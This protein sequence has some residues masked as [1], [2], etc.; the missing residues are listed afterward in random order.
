MKQPSR[1]CY[2]NGKQGPTAGRRKFGKETLPMPSFARGRLAVALVLFFGSVTSWAQTTSASGAGRATQ[3]VI[4]LSQGTAGFQPQNPF[5]GSVPAGTATPNVLPLSLK[6]AIARGL[7]QN[8]GLLLTGE[9]I[10][11]ARGQRPVPCFPDGVR[12]HQR[13]GCLVEDL[14]NAGG[15]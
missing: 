15:A 8:L 2:L 14:A 13:P 10:P 3:Y 12:P 7:K 4:T 6:D 5:S 11:A 9:E 1:Y